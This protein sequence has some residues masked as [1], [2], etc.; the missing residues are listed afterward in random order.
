MSG[1]QNSAKAAGRTRLPGHFKQTIV[2]SPKV[3]E[4]AGTLNRLSLN[5]VCEE[6]RCPNRNNCYSEG[7]ATFLIMG[8]S[9]TRS[10]SFCAVSKTAPQPLDQNEPYSVARAARDLKLKYVVVTSVTRDDLEDGGAGHF[11]RVINEV[12]SMNPA[13]LIEVLTPDFQGRPESVDAVIA[14]RPN[15]FNHN[16]ET[17]ERLY[18]VVRPQAEYRRSLDLISRV[19][20]HGLVAKSGLMVG[21]GETVPEIK[22]VMADLADCG[23]DIVTIG[24]YL[25]PSALHHPVARYWEPGEFEEC[26][27]YGQDV[28]GFKS[29]VAGPLVRSSYYAHQTY[30]RINH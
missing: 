7:T 18:P 25:A 27:D 11:V 17:I 21:L 19:K 15:V 26:R 14:A 2:R 3:D 5:T 12:R 13:S 20:R 29:V 16:L 1:E 4:V 22:N 30:Q 8:G 24:Q 9:C 6:A 10:C 28:L 23:C